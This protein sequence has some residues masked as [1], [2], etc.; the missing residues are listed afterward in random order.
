MSDF[1]KDVRATGPLI[2]ATVRVVD[3]IRTAVEAAERLGVAHEG[4]RYSF[5]CDAFEAFEIEVRA[6]EKLSREK[7]ARFHV[8]KRAEGLLAV[9]TAERYLDDED[10]KI[11]AKLRKTAPE[12]W[13][14]GLKELLSGHYNRLVEAYEESDAKDAAKAKGSVARG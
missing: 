14:A 13:E 11:I 3:G 9:L 7:L 4:N 6:A 12:R 8:D 5:A 2:W 1:V 10:R